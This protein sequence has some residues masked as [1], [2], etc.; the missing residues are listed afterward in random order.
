MITDELLPL[1][2]VVAVYV[3]ST[4]LSASESVK[5]SKHTSIM[6]CA[7][8]TFGD[9]MWVAVN[10]LSYITGKS[11]GSFVLKNDK[12]KYKVAFLILVG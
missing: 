8:F 11:G 6:T 4:A 9:E 1:K 12:Y 2:V 3:S 5:A 7:T 10:T